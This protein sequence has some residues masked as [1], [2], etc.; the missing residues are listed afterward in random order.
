M[1]I[2]Y[3]YQI[4]VHHTKP[5]MDVVYIVEKDIERMIF[6]VEPEMVNFI[7]SDGYANIID[8]SICQFNN[9]YWT[10]CAAH[11][12]IEL[13]LASIWKQAP[14]L[15]RKFKKTSALSN[16]KLGS[17][18]N[19]GDEY[20]GNVIV[21]ESNEIEVLK[22]IDDWLSKFLLVRGRVYKLSSAPHYEVKSTLL[23]GN[24]G[25]TE[26]SFSTGKVGGRTL[27]FTN[28]H[29][30][31]EK[32]KSLAEIRNHQLVFKSGQFRSRKKSPEL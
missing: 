17:P 31:V 6:E 32:A 5:T 25:K 13:G 21:L 29:E 23:R 3:L 24:R 12:E 4:L 1:K 14:C 8:N 28:F 19:K 26:V 22:L 9:D 15:A 11:N 27:E 20:I 18:M 7:V 30:A 16:A 10:E 2:S